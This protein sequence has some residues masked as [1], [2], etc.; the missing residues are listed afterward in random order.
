VLIYRSRDMQVFGF[1]P[2]AHR[3]ARKQAIGLTAR[4]RVRGRW[5]HVRVYVYWPRQDLRVG[6]GYASF[7]MSSWLTGPGTTKRLTFRMLFGVR[8]ALG[9]ARP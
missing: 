3:K 5:R 4:V 6:R 7:E 8:I 9:G 1:T 2:R